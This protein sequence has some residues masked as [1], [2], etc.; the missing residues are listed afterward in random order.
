MRNRF[1]E[2]LSEL[3]ESLIQLG[4]IIE[5]AIDN[6]IKA[7][8]NQDI[9]LANLVIEDDKEA[10]TLARKIESEALVLL[11]R[12]QPVARDLRI[13]TTALKIVTDMERIAKQA[14]DICNIVLYLADKKYTTNFVILPKMAQRTKEMVNLCIESFISLDLELARKVIDM[15]DA[16]DDL[17]IQVKDETERKTKEDI[18]YLDRGLHYMMIAKYFEKIGDHA[19]NIADWV[20]FCKTGEKKN[21]KLI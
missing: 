11:L 5:K 12:Q 9:E 17:Y 1:E 8:V 21:V 20:I 7:L 14:S 15:D 2:A 6:S 3:N 4:K 16:V 18:G 13:V 19:E 10:G